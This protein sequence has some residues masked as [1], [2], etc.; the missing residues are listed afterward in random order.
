MKFREWNR[1][2]IGILD[3]ELEETVKSLNDL[4]HQ[5][6]DESL[7]IDPLSLAELRREASSKV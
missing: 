4:D 6:A 7:V 2:V 5:V 1:E 3:L